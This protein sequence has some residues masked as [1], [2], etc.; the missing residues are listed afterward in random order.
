MM[1]A[2][3]PGIRRLCCAYDVEKYSV[4]THQ[5][6]LAVQQRL[7][8]VIKAA[9]AAAAL[10]PDDYRIQPQGDG[11]LLLLPTGGDVDEPLLIA[12]LL[13]TMESELRAVND[14]AAAGDRVRMRVAL[15]EGVVYDGSNGYAGDAVIEV[16]RMCEAEPVKRALAR[17][18]LADLVLVASDGLYRGVLRH[19]GH[20]LPAG[21]FDAISVRVKE[22]SAN[23]WL[24]ISGG[25]KPAEAAAERPAAPEN[26]PPPERR[27]L[28][29]TL[30]GDESYDTF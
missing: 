1:H 4:R 30:D 11:G 28:A 26:P 6:Q 7:A 17:A 16:C 10:G 15:H 25:H 8:R 14:G 21:E 13:R 18:P 12:L 29:S 5:G 2:R 20:G 19:G 24:Y 23:C 9:C 27:L 3:P 22:F